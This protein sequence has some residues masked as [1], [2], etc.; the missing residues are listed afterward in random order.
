M[1]E[2]YTCEVI[3]TVNMVVFTYEIFVRSFI[4]Q[5]PSPYSDC[6][7]FP[8][9]T[10]IPIMT[11]GSYPYF[12]TSLH[13]VFGK[14]LLH[15]RSTFKW[16]HGFINATFLMWIVQG[17]N[18]FFVKTLRWVWSYLSGHIHHFQV[19]PSLCCLQNVCTYECP[20]TN[21]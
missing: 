7:S 4:I 8:T 14:I 6:F 2:F 21:L 5:P 19:V 1:E 12:K 3:I 18:F 15:C 20:W 16:Y 10:N 11:V 9:Y 13:W 17:N